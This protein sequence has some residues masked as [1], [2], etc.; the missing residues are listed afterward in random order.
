MDDSTK[1]EVAY[2]VPPYLRV[3]KDGS[4]ERLLGTDILPPSLDIQTGVSSKDIII[5][6][7]SG[8]SARFYL[9]K[10]THNHQKKLPLIIYFHGGA[11]CISS[12]SDPYY[13][14]SLNRQAF[15]ANAIVVSVNYRLVPEHPLPT[16]YDDSWTV[17]QWV[18]SH[19]SKLGD[20]HGPEAW[21]N[22][23]ADFD[24]VFLAGDS[25][26]AN[27]AHHLAM[28]VAEK[29][30]AGGMKLLGVIIVHPYFWGEEAI[31]LEVL[32]PARKAMVDKWWLY[33][34]PLPKGNDHPL[35]NPVAVGA[36]SL[37]RLGCKRV[38]VCVAEK[39]ILRDRGRLYY[40]SL[41]KS[42]WPG[43]AEIIETEGED[44]DFH[45]FN[46]TCEK[47]V[48]IMK[49]FASFINQDKAPLLK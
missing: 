1:R 34:C 32:D 13:H 2:E 40:E 11:F 38:L 20:G 45:I 39:D 31:G 3:F 43:G 27:I 15:H 25:S 16:A 44:H 36:P 17:L 9:P 24:R 5:I 23:Y 48:D 30:L 19:Y 12:V 29:E 26:G 41:V 8:L 14:H 42:G 49:S 33:V 22:G 46:P 10:I 35:I 37:A 18:A 21:L 7:E 4:V 28:W 47:A 6:P